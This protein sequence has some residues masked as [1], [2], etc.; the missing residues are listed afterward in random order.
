MFLLVIFKDLQQT[1][2]KF[3]IKF[4]KMKDIIRLT[5]GI[6]SYNTIRQRT[7]KKYVTKQN[8]YKVIRL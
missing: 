1:S 8:L 4:R 6:I 2:P 5:N 7:D 3:I